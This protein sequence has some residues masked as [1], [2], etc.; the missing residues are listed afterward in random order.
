MKNFIPVNNLKENSKKY[1]DCIALEIEN[2]KSDIVTIG[3]SYLKNLGIE[4]DEFFCFGINIFSYFL[5]C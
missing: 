2:K 1:R 4:S 3:I 5:N